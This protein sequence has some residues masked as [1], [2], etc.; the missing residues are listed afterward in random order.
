M[1]AAEELPTLNESFAHRYQAAARDRLS[2][3]DDL[4]YFPSRP[5]LVVE[6]RPH[7]GRSWSGAFGEEWASPTY[8]TGLYTTPDRDTICVVSSGAGYFV[9]TTEPELAWI[10]VTCTPIRLVLP[11]PKL[12]LLVFGNFT[13]FTAYRLDPEHATVMKIA[14]RSA[15]LGWDDLAVTR[16]TDDRIE[17]HAWHAPDDRMVGFSL[18][19]ATGEHEGGAYPPES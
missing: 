16:T 19:V 13:D 3:P 5:T 18:D 1:G 10:P 12:G 9:E 8:A 17:G 15:R 7:R 4:I 14:W 2:T 6:V 11:F